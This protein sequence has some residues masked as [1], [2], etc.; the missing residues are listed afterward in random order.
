M[1]YAERPPEAVL[2]KSANYF[3]GYLVV[4]IGK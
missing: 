3:E 4:I 1:L 2:L